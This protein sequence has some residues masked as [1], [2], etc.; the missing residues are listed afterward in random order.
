[1]KKSKFAKAL[2]DLMIEPEILT[3][4]AWCAIIDPWVEYKQDG[5]TILTFGP[6]AVGAPKTMALIQS[7]FDDEALP[8]EQHLSTIIGACEEGHIGV[9]VNQMSSGDLGDPEFRAYVERFKEGKGKQEEALLNLYEVLDQWAG[10]V[11]PLAESIPR[12]NL[13]INKIGGILHAQLFSRL[14][15]ELMT[16]PTSKRQDMIDEIA[17]LIRVKTSKEEV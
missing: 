3:I 8:S 17:Q 12:V 1:M 10:E 15:V 6:E 14:F 7:W 13:Q 2:Y 5:G 16:I 4:E 11:S 9:F